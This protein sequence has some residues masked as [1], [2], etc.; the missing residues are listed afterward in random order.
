MKPVKLTLI[1]FGPY[2]NR[3]V[4]DFRDLQ[5]QSLFVISGNTGA[6]KTTIFDGICFALYG[7]ANGEERNDSKLLRSHFANDDDH[8][9]V[10]FDF[11]L[12]GKTYRVFRQLPHVKKN[13][14]T[15]T[16]GKIE[17]YE[18]TDGQL[19]PCVER[20]AVTDV[21]RKLEQLIGLTK[22]QF[23]QIVM[24][25]QGEFR[26]LLTSET[27]NKEEIL[28]RIFKTESLK[29]LRDL[30][31]EKT[32]EI[33]NKADKKLAEKQT[34]MSAITETLPTREEASL[35]E[36]LSLEH[37]NT[38]QLVE[39]LKAEAH[40]Y[41]QQAVRYRAVLKQE[42]E[43]YQ[44]KLAAF[45]QAEA[46]NE[47]F[48]LLENK[49]KE[50]AVLHEKQVDMKQVE[51]KLAQAEKAEA[52]RFYE[53]QHES[54]T[55]EKREKAG[56]LERATAVFEQVTDVFE[57]AKARYEQ[58]EQNE[59]RRKK[60]NI[61]VD[62]L[63][64]LL[65]MFEQMESQKQEIN[66]LKKMEAE[67]LNNS[68]QLKAVSSELEQKKTEKTEEINQIETE[69]ST[70]QMT[71]QELTTA[72]ETVETLETILR[73]R[74]DE[75][76]L[77]AEEQR[78]GEQVKK[79][80]EDY[81]ELEDQWLENQA[82][83][84]AEHLHADEP[85]PVC[86][87]AE[88][89]HKANRTQSAVTKEQVE[90]KRNH[91]QE[92]EASLNQAVIDLRTVQSQIKANETKLSQAEIPL[93]NVQTTYEEW[94][95]KQ[96]NLQEEHAR[97]EQQQQRLQAVKKEL[98]QLD[99]QLTQRLEVKAEV[100]DKYQQT[101]RELEVKQALFEA[102]LARIPNEIETLTMLKQ[103][104][105]IETERQ[106]QLEQAWKQAQSNLQEES[107]R[108][109]VAKSDL[110]HIR[111]AL[112]ELEVKAE[113]TERRFFAE[114]SRAGFS[115]VEEYKRAKM[116]EPS[117]LAAKKEL[118]D[119]KTS[120]QTLQSQIDELTKELSGKSR[121]DLE[122]LQQDVAHIYDVCERLRTELEQLTRYQNEAVKLKEKIEQ[123]DQQGKEIEAEYQVMTDLFEVVKGNNEMKLS[124]ERYLQIEFLER[125]IAAANERL[126]TI[127]NGQFYLKRRDQVEKGGKQS[128][129]GLDVYD[130]YTGQTRDV[131]SLSGGEKFNASL[132]LA[133]GMADVIQSYQGG[134]SIDTMF[135]DEGF[136][137]LDEESLYKAIQTLV[138]L[139]KAGRMIG[140]IS[141]VQELKNTIPAVLE[142]K[143]S[144]EGH[145]KTRF[146]V[147]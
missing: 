138:D 25:P 3:E 124:F 23:T 106:Q 71:H 31:D 65:P 107:E 50:I 70:W 56:S 111:T 135:I 104:L 12:R 80:K 45:H 4:I 98:E 75:G 132:C 37:P 47:R 92:L 36:V 55:R 133:L 40:Y 20:F 130:A 90:Q 97:L 113:D 61:E 86:G 63:N 108:Y 18:T 146:V 142:V 66:Q 21:N 13:N 134:I 34:Y 139:Q 93:S 58:E 73:L 11:E 118:D 103:K 145:S 91:L 128:G 141:H 7:V 19:T 76:R 28:R 69:V 82:A 26:K 83:V 94:V 15:A 129:L 46:L 137:S 62:R 53:E 74:K 105:A 116:D 48:S 100:E 57:R 144:K 22:E 60:A 126:R 2:R 131:K 72:N 8:T 51:Q 87:S 67:L 99:Q 89:P 110:A 101:S 27:A 33:K 120:L 95:L 24:L 78:Q 143:K 102:E 147:R 127:S 1:A 96:A 54:V 64:E 125:I 81:K 52:I 39:G 122:A 121:V 136:G 77:Q 6:G 85:C 84:L 29:F 79:V 35:F 117:R 112:K 32:K 49:Q 14:K 59:E 123:A 88:H 17:L 16:G 38:A 114:V 41:E 9:A 43:Q 109:T 5:E 30:L 42:Q 68:E 140:V 115:D 10:E 119:F 44:K